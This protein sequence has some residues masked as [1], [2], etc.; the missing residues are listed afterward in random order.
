[1]LFV[2]ASGVAFTFASR[3]L[4]WPVAKWPALVLLPFYLLIAFSTP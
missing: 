3:R 1:L 2:A 4:D